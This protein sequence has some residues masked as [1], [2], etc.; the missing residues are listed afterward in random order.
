LCAQRDVRNV[1]L[2]CWT[3]VWVNARAMQLNKTLT[4]QKNGDFI[5]VWKVFDVNK[6]PYV[7][8]AK[9]IKKTKKTS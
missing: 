2:S 8:S 5:A 9:K 4:R 3:D 6:G 1:V 7:K